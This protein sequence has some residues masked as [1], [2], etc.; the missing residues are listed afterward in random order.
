MGSGSLF[1]AFSDIVA[2]YGGYKMISGITRNNTKDVSDGLQF[3]MFS[4]TGE[5]FGAVA[6]KTF[7]VIS[8][9]LRPKIAFDNYLNTGG[10]NYAYAQNELL[11][12]YSY[13]G[14]KG[15]ELDLNIPKNLQGQGL[16]AKIF[17]QAIETTKASKFTATWIRSEMYAN[18]SSIN[19]QRFYDAIK[20]GA[21]ESDAAWS[22]WSGGQA[23]INGFKNVS[24]KY[25]PQGIE[26]TLTK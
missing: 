8:P 11:G 21:S 19:L 26:A 15:L 4:A 5:I 24:V 14:N 12:H 17:K 13:S 20:G 18:G 22:T 10:S 25:L 9:M 1:T 3:I 2:S 7:E 6:N 16:G 23:K